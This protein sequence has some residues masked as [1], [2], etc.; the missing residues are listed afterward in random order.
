MSG[1][2]GITL[3]T[4][5]VPVKQ[6]A[7]KDELQESC[8]RLVRWGCRNVGWASRKYVIRNSFTEFVLTVQ[9]W[10]MFHC[11]ER[12]EL[13]LPKPGNRLGVAAWN[14]VKGWESKASL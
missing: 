14:L 6:I 12:V 7:D 4:S 8:T 2:E 10:E 5:V 9:V 13:S 11:C 3:G 1:L